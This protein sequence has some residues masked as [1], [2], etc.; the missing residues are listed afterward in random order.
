MD[1]NKDFENAWSC[2]HC[3][4]CGKNILQHLKYN[5]N[6]MNKTA[7]T[8]LRQK[9]KEKNYLAKKLRADKYNK[10]NQDKKRK[11]QKTYEEDQREQ[12]KEYYAN[13]REQKKKYYADNREQ[14]NEYQRKYYDDNRDQRKAYQR[15]YDKEHKKEQKVK[16]KFRRGYIRNGGEMLYYKTHWKDP[17]SI[18]M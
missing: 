10:E 11:Y 12:K 8:V 7:I 18:K 5:T 4:W 9:V 3:T 13:N 15:N 1:E 14:K 6:C 17:I 2:E 16:D